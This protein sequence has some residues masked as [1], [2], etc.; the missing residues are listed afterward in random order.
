MLS[1]GELENACKSCTKCALYETRTNVVFG[2]GNTGAEV[3]FVGEGPGEQEDLKAEPFV[4]RA[5]SCW[6]IC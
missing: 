1:W 2:V 4:G 5:G 3:L 6:T